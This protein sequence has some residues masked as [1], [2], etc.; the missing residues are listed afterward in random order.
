MMSATRGTRVSREGGSVIV[1]LR[2]TKRLTVRVE[3][4]A[5]FLTPESSATYCCA[6]AAAAAEA[7]RSGGIGG[8]GK[9]RVFVPF[10]ATV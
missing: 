9:K 5:D 7:C 8:S 6:A 3:L 4:R 2:C 1:G 10:L